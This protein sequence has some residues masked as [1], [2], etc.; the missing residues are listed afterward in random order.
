M[1]RRTWF[2]F[3]VELCDSRLLRWVLRRFKRKIVYT[4]EWGTYDTLY[5]STD[6]GMCR[7]CHPDMA[8]APPWS[9][10]EIVPLET[11]SK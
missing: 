8:V 3:V 10:L 6:L 9:D 7:P 2:L 5:D 11:E 1:K 4:C